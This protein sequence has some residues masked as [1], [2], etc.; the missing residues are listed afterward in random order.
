MKEFLQRD[1]IRSLKKSNINEK[2]TP[3]IDGGN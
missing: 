1:T 3:G 2:L